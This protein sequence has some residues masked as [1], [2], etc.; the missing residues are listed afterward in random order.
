MAESCDSLER[1]AS[2]MKT[3]ERYSLH[4]DSD[5]ISARSLPLKQSNSQ[6]AMN[7]KGIAPLEKGFDGDQTHSI[8]R[9]KGRGNKRNFLGNRRPTA[10]GRNVR[11][12]RLQNSANY[13]KKDLSIGNRS[14][15]LIE[16]PTATRR[17]YPLCSSQNVPLMSIP[18]PETLQQNPWEFDF[19]ADAMMAANINYVEVNSN[20]NIT[21]RLILS[22]SYYSR[23]HHK[24]VRL[25]GCITTGPEN[26]LYQ[27][28]AKRQGPQ[29]EKMSFIF[30]DGT[31]HIDAICINELV[32]SKSGKKT[33]PRIPK[34]S[35]FVDCIGY[36]QHIA[37][38]ESANSKAGSTL[39]F[40]IED[41]KFIDDIALETLRMMNVMSKKEKRLQQTQKV[42]H[43]MMGLKA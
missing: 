19:L 43:N 1:N 22:A 8:E 6:P 27:E 34:R 39:V 12:R 4:K 5:N 17:P 26:I 41:L 7:S 25:M 33:L 3:A 15:T 28:G 42:S 10:I 18:S 37:C 20:K 14:E 11:N 29:Q 9:N 23:C 13:L 16:S 30:D 40:M 36:I 31:S 32:E 38:N 24:T 2:K 21:E 35:D